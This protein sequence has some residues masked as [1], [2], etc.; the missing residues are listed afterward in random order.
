ML[1]RRLFTGD[2]S[3]SGPEAK[4]RGTRGSG[5]SRSMASRRGHGPLGPSGPRWWPLALG[6][7]ALLA[8]GRVA[9]R[10]R[11][12]RGCRPARGSRGPRQSET[13]PPAD[14]R[15]TAQPTTSASSTPEPTTRGLTPALSAP[16]PGAA[17]EVAVLG[18]LRF[19]GTGSPAAGGRSEDVEATVRSA[20]APNQVE[21]AP[22]GIRSDWRCFL[23]L[24]EQAEAVSPTDGLLGLSILARALALVRGEPLEGL[25]AEWAVAIADPLR[26]A[27][28]EAAQRLARRALAAD[29]PHL[30]TWATGQG[31]LA[32]P[33]AAQLIELRGA[34]LARRTP[35]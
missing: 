28:A 21:A 17:P 32:A 14:S 20:V 24:A 3:D 34:A 31:L 25:D 29:R 8:G 1:V 26:S 19:S 5:S 33:N 4:G 2:A 12:G 6:G 13:A 18:P 7:L 30:A 35:A 23:A 16:G 11:R 9:T 15:A 10:T 27:V 22:P